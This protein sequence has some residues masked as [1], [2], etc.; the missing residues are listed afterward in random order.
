MSD[1]YYVEGSERIGPRSLAEMEE[2]ILS[3]HLNEES[4]VWTGGF[5]NWARL[6]D[7]DELATFLK[8]DLPPAIDEMPPIID[9]VEAVTY[10]W[11]TLK[12]DDKVINIKIGLDRGGEEMEYGPYTVGEIRRAFSQKRINAKTLAFIPGDHEW[13]FLSDISIF[14]DLFSDAEN[15]SVEIIDQSTKEKRRSL[16]K[17]FIAKMFVHDQNILLEGVCRD[18]STGGL[19]VLVSNSPF[20]IGEEITLNVHPDNS[21]Y[22]FVANGLVVRSLEANQGFALR[23]VDLDSEAENAIT[24]YLSHH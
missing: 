5:D 2:L 15:N 1:W 22:H 19:Q 21:D 6:G 18:I 14:S 20:Q 23:F 13:Q 7:V 11:E 24:T 10:T 17:P 12:A 9:N 16:R 4:F 3:K 8:N